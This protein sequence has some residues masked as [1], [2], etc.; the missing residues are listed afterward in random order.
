MIPIWQQISQSSVMKRN[1]ICIVV[2]PADR[3]RL[4]AI[5]ADRNSASKHVW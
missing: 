2:S 3:A 1:D 4:E 5:V